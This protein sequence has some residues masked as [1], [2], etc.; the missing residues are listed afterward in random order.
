QVV[1]K[2]ASRR[3]RPA[4]EA[5]APESPKPTAEEIPP[6]TAAEPIAKP[7]LVPP[8]G[9]QYIKLGRERSRRA[10]LHAVRSPETVK[11]EP[12]VE[13]AHAKVIEPIAE[14][15]SHEGPWINGAA[16]AAYGL[17]TP[18]EPAREAAAIAPD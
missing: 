12:V 2:R 7:E 14:P 1:R 5:P 15:V 17:E 18:K 3:A 9:G 11:A 16:S 4:V 10:R 8:A 6:A 13:A